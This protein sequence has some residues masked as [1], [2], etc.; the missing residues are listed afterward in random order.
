MSDTCSDC[1]SQQI[2]PIILKTLFHLLDEAD[3]KPLEEEQVEQMNFCLHLMLG[4]ASPKCWR[5]TVSW[6]KN[7]AD[8]TAEAHTLFMTVINAPHGTFPKDWGSIQ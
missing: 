4:K 5:C 3:T 6:R 7:R 1:V 2:A 8:R